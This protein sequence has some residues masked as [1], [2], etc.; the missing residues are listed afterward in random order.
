MG[1]IYALM[2]M[3]I[4]ALL[5]IKTRKLNPVFYIISLYF[6]FM[7]ICWII[8]EATYINVFEGTYLIVF[9]VISAIMLVIVSGIYFREKRKAQ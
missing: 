4:G 3:I 5:F 1:Y 9:R 2:W 6:E 7:G 8:N